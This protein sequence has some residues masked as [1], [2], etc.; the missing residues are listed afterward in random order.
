M[1]RSISAAGRVQSTSP[2]AFVALR[3]KVA[4]EW[5]WG[6][7]LIRPV[8]P[9]AQGLDKQTAADIRESFGQPA[10]GLRRAYWHFDGTQD[11]A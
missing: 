3:L 9:V 7:G 5:S 6:L 11:R 1:R 8:G 10:G 2:S 4:R